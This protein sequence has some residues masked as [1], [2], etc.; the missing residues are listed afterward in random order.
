MIL[1]HFTS[2]GHLRG[3]AIYG[4]T[5]G[6][7][8]T[9]RKRQR[10]RIGVWLTSS[11]SPGG[12]GLHGS[13]VDKTSY[14]LSVSVDEGSPSLHRWLDWVHGNVTTD[15]IDALHKAAAQT[16]GDGPSTWFVYFG[17]LPPESIVDCVS[18][19]TGESIKNWASITSPEMDIKPVPPWRREAWQRKMLKQVRSVL[20][21]SNQ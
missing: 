4:L 12:H 8:P 14:R 6:D 11:E 5:V 17:V 16:E 13:G 3:I 10:G 20:R 2:P 19:R 7:V 15:T 21:R 1:Y 18:V 9:D